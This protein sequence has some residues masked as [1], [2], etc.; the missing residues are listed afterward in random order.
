M[1]PYQP[2]AVLA[3]A[4]LPAASPAVA[5]P[6]N[7]NIVNFAETATA[8]VP[9]DTMYATFQIRAEGGDR[10]AVNRNFIGKLNR[11]TRRIEGGKAFK[12]EQFNRNIFPR[13]QYRPNKPPV[14]GGWEESVYIKVESRDFAA[15]NRLIA[16]SQNDA[17]IRNTAFDVSEEKRRETVRRVSKD[18]LSRFKG[19]AAELGGVLGSPDYK[20]VSL[21]LTDSAETGDFRMRA[22]FSAAAP[23][24][25][26]AGE[27]AALTADT[28]DA[29]MEEIRVTVSGAVQ[30]Q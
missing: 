16:E 15:L 27:N 28:P 14:V 29:G 19:R 26:K 20:I 21:N 30:F 13:Y 9:R 6:L 5:E 1:R 8:T 25:A 12:S 10:A 23:M 11:F 17:E 7:Y 3:A 24:E 4:L 22:N 2:L 18:A